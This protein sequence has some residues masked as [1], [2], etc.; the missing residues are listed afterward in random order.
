MLCR[1]RTKKVHSKPGRKKSKKTTPQ[2]ENVATPRTIAA[3][4]REAAQAATEAAQAIE[5]VARE[6]TRVADQ[7]ANAAAREEAEVAEAEA[8]KKKRRVDLDQV[9]LVVAGPSVP[10]QALAKKVTPRKKL[11]TKVKK[12]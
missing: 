9:P 2:A 11:A 8:S 6:A 4:V 7:A 5:E 3:T 10:V 1:K 12:S